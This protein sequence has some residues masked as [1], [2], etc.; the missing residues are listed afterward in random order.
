MKSEIETADEEQTIDAVPVKHGKW[1]RTTYY[2]CSE[3]QF[4]M[5]YVTPYC[6]F[7]GAK[8]ELEE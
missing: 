7:C 4:L 1:N 5:E 2:E 3:C 8:M 6:P